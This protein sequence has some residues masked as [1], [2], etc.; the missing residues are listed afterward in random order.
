MPLAEQL[1]VIVTI[2]SVVIESC[3]TTIHHVSQ[4]KTILSADN[5]GFKPK[6]RIFTEKTFSQKLSLSLKNFDSCCTY[7]FTVVKQDV[8]W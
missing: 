5:A 4:K 1:I 6:T 8:Q 7:S 3:F 2:N